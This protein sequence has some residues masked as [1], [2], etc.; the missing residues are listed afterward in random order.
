[1][2]R[3]QLQPY[4]SELRTVFNRVCALAERKTKEAAELRIE[5]QEVRRDR[6]YWIAANALV[7]AGIVV[8]WIA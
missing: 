2:S 8:R 6:R 3:Q 5:L 7:W 1:M 4:K